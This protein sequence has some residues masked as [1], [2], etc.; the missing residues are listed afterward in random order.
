M[1]EGVCHC[2]AVR[3]TFEGRPEWVTACN[4]TICRRYG[5]LWAYGFD[6]E[7][8]HVFGATAVYARGSKWLG[9]H[10]CTRCACVAYWHQTQPGADGRRRVGVNVRL[11]E[12]EAVAAIP[13][14]HHDGLGNHDDFPPDGRR[15]SDLWS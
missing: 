14:N 6:N 5:A 2:G 10:F 1:I 3:W 15:V 9:F 12:P 13:I 4:C 8:V 11:A 7:G